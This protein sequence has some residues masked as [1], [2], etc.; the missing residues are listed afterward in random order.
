MNLYFLQGIS[1]KSERGS[2][3]EKELNLSAMKTILKD[4][5]GLQEAT[6]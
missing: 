1:R 4:S 2:K 6:P 5:K 3:H